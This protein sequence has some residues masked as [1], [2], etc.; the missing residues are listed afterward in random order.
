MKVYKQE[1]I[2]FSQI[3]E[4]E[5]RKYA[6]MLANAPKTAVADTRAKQREAAEFLKKQMEENRMRDQA[7]STLQKT[8]GSMWQDEAMRQ[9]MEDNENRQ[10]K[11]E[12]QAHLRQVYLDQIEE[13]EKA[14]V[15][16]CGLTETEMK[17]QSHLL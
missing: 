10:K 3:E 2:K 13:K 6:Q 16:Q 7:Y 17:F 8:Q 1:P 9:S 5:D 14:F 11:K 4:E 15:D 12:N